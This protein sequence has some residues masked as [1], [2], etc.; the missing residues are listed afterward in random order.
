MK[1]QTRRPRFLIVSPQQCGGG[2]VVLHLLC[3]ML[4]D[5]GYDAR[6]FRLRTDY[7]IS[8]P[9]SRREFLCHY[10]P[11][12]RKKN[13]QIL[14]S[15]DGS[16]KG[17]VLT[18]WPYVDDD[19]IVVYPEIVFGNPLA[20]RHVVRWFLNRNTFKGQYVGEQPYGKDDL[21]ICYWKVFNDYQLNPSGRQVTLQNFNHDVYKRWNYGHREGNCFLIHKGLYRKDLP[22]Q[23]P[24]IIIDRLSEKEKV[25]VLN[26][27]EYFYSFD[28]QTSYLYVAAICGCVSIAI[29]E[30]GKSRTD[31]TGGEVKAWGVA[32]GTSPEELAFA[33]S[34]YKELQAYIESF[35]IQNHEN[36]HKFLAYCQEYFQPRMDQNLNWER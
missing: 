9:G 28:P 1:K 19:T 26:R 18:D 36:V 15:Q 12:I 34:T 14:D 10:L 21:F 5:M 25:E 2:P 30:P 16:I 35:D 6:I 8:L 27:C 17:C 7:P 29:P 13:K 32:Y 20:A 11:F 3:H 4:A 22:T 24:G 23:V 31:Y 33:R